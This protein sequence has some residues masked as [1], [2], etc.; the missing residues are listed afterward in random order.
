MHTDIYLNVGKEPH[1]DVTQSS[2]SPECCWVEF[3]DKGGELT[4][5]YCTPEQLRDLA[6]KINNT[7]RVLVPTCDNDMCPEIATHR[8]TM[9]GT[10]DESETV[11]VFCRKHA[12]PN[13]LLPYIHDVVTTVRIDALA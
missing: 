11:Y 6:D 9:L 7:L 3:R 1:I 8:V 12:E 13:L 5:L 10:A 4:T 2:T